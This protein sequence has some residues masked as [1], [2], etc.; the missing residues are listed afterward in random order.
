VCGAL[1]DG[2]IEDAVRAA[3]SYLPSDEG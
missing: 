2:R 3:D 1:E